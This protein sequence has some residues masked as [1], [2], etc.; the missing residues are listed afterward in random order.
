MIYNFD[1]TIKKIQ[2]GYS[3]IRFGDGELQL[4][5]NKSIRFQS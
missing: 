3:I 5:R 1:D 4:L 2:V